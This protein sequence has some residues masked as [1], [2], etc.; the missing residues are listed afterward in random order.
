MSVS[1]RVPISAYLSEDNDLEK[2]RNNVQEL[3]KLDTPQVL[4]RL[5]VI[6]NHSPRWVGMFLNAGFFSGV[7]A[8]IWFL[9]GVLALLWLIAFYVAWL[10]L[11]QPQPLY[12]FLWSIPGIAWFAIIL[13]ANESI[14]KALNFKSLA[15]AYSFPQLVDWGVLGIRVVAWLIGLAFIL[16]GLASFVLM[17]LYGAQV[18]ANLAIP[19]LETFELPNW[20]FYFIVGIMLL[21]IT[22]LLFTRFWWIGMAI[23]WGIG[24]YWL[25]EHDVLLFPVHLPY[26]DQSFPF[27]YLFI[28]LS[29]LFV[30]RIPQQFC[31]A[32]LGMFRA[33]ESAIIRLARSIKLRLELERGYDVH[34]RRNR[35]HIAADGEHA[36]C[37]Q[38]LEYFVSKRSGPVTY[39]W[40]PRCED[41]YYAYQRV[42]TIQGV[43]DTRMS[44]HHEQFDAL[45]HINLLNWRR[46]EQK[47]PALSLQEIMIGKLDDPHEVEWFLTKYRE[48]QPKERNWAPIH[49]IKPLFHPESNVDEHTRRVV[50]GMFAKS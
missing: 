33:W 41:D 20:L 39:W 17:T 45:L 16:L 46:K 11:P 31:L 43:M 19:W 13:Y 18:A 36:I 2:M 3:I 15:P 1:K 23:F 27:S 48:L 28:I 49:N 21:G 4:P 37:R 14:R 12:G 10:R 38:D 8:L 47:P 25:W 42:Q 6:D 44:A 34:R 24:S 35:E 29:G 40:C 26:T 30:L 50:L 32:S 7:A 9:M 5:H 22:G